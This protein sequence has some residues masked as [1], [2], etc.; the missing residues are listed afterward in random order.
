M[1]KLPAMPFVNGFLRT[2]STELD[3][4]PEGMVAIFRRD[5]GEDDKG[6]VIP[7]TLTKKKKALGGCRQL[8]L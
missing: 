1:A 6:K 7:V 2:I 4:K 3:L 5:F 8:Q